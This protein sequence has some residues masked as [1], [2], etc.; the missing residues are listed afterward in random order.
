MKAVAYANNNV[1]V[2][3]WQ[4]DLP[5]DG[6]LGFDVRRID[7]TTGQVTHLSAW[8]PFVGEDNSQWQ[9]KTTDVWPVQKFTW[10]D[11][12]A[13]R[14]RELCYVI[15]PMVGAPG[16]LTPRED[17]AATTNPVCLGIDYGNISVAFNSGILA[18]Q[19]L[20][21]QL[22]PGSGGG[23]SL[24]AL[25]ADI[26]TPD[27]PLR[28]DLAGDTLPL[29]RNLLQRVQSQGGE[30]YAA[31]Y[32]L[33]DPELIGLL[34]GNTAVHL[35]LSNTGPDDKENAP[36]RKLLHD[37]GVDIH[38]RLLGGDHIGHNK[39]M[40]YVDAKGQPQA[41]LTG[42]TNWTANGMC[43]Q[44]NNALLIQSPVVAQHYLDYW[45]ALLQDG[46][47]Q[48]PALRTS[49]QTSRL[50]ALDGGN[51]QLENWFSPNTKETA[52]PS[53]DPPAPPDMDEVFKL[54]QAAQHAVLFLV[55]LP[56]TPSIVDA[57]TQVATDKPSLF[58]RGA[59]S[60]P[61]AMPNGD[62]QL[63]HRPGQAWDI[64]PATGIKDEFAAWHKELLSAGNAIIHDKIV[65][66]DPLSDDCVVIT[67]SHNLGYKASY[68]NDENLLIIRGNRALAQAY[69]VH[70]LDVYDHYRFRL[71]QSQHAD[72]PFSGFL[73][74]T[75]D[76]QTPYAGGAPSGEVAYWVSGAA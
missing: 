40:V 22:P 29:L 23:P 36:T 39:F 74:P 17:L 59:V 35:I 10:R 24:T 67:G 9:A 71:I 51:T 31:L 45:N 28:L 19:F 66:I 16:N 27:N 3:A 7:Q 75:P 42:S 32:E 25:K 68:S 33:A 5:I 1:A 61:K 18:T 69:A 15:V 14:G 21:H 58:M 44:S 48:G 56:G 2:L 76:W 50:A 26:A 60:D 72:H 41:V 43:A 53:H 11:F 62:V 70:V 6:C 8:E 46:S 54:I 55:F 4:Y 20:A 12:E 13:P 37:S 65:V 34:K 47:V 38:D 57:C 52:K 64:V 49:N 73:S 30:C 63:F